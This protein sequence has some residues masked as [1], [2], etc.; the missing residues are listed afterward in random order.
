MIRR[1]DDDVEVYA[2]WNADGLR[3]MREMDER[4]NYQLG[5]NPDMLENIY[6]EITRRK[7]KFCNEG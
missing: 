1:G 7:F 3:E 2:N 4:W 6:L 5:W